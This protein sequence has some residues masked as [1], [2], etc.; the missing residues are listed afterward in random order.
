MQK[1]AKKKNEKRRFRIEMVEAT[2]HPQNIIKK[3]QESGKRGLQG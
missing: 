2:H 3:G 1:G